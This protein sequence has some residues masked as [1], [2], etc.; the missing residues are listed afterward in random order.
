MH[1]KHWLNTPLVVNPICDLFTSFMFLLQFAAKSQ[2]LTLL[3]MPCCTLRQQ[4]MTFLLPKQ[5]AIAVAPPWQHP[6]LINPH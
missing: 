2:I 5:E 4:C 3:L 6:A 1:K